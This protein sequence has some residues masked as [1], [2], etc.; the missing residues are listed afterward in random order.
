MSVSIADDEDRRG[1]GVGRS[2][3]SLGIPL[4]YSCFVLSKNLSILIGRL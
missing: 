4:D 1:G 2:Y 3:V